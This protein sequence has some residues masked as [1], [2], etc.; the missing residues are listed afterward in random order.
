MTTAKAFFESVRK[1]VQREQQLSDKVKMLS[2]KVDGV[3][4][5]DYTKDAVK[6]TSDGKALERRV[7]L[8][9]DARSAYDEQRSHTDMLIEQAS[10]MLN[11]MRDAGCPS[12]VIDEL[13]YYYVWN[14]STKDISDMLHLS[15]SRIRAHRTEALKASD[16][17]VP[18]GAA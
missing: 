8:M 7:I 12:S 9:L 17:F 3:G 10:D 18:L 11:A 5:M 13:E 15:A 14:M 16:S 1:A 4:C 6:A 2:E